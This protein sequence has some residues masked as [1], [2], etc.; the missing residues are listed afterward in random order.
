MKYFFSLKELFH[1]DSG[2]DNRVPC[3]EVNYVMHNLQHLRT[4]LNL[5]RGFMRQPIKVNSCYRNSEVNSAV[6]GV[7]TSYHMQGR[8]A[9][10]TCDNL[11]DLKF[12]C[13]N[14]FEQGILVECVLHESYIHI[15]I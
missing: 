4:T 3:K 6:G 8:A 10:I 14:L 15:A 12:L 13:L 1:T 11:H 5:I 9:D 7:P 2:V